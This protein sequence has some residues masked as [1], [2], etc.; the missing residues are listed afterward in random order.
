MEK[1]GMKKLIIA[2]FLGMLLTVAHA[3]KTVQFRNNALGF[4]MYTT[5]VG[6]TSFCDQNANCIDFDDPNQIESGVYT[7][8]NDLCK[9]EI[10]KVESNFSNGTHSNDFML[11]I[12][13]NVVKVLE[14]VCELDQTLPAQKRSIT[15][16]YVL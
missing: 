9:I 3:G 14:G 6:V 1:T 16:I 12:T 7:L 10:E 11:S 5:V 13:Y 2:A 15:G 8:E 4:D